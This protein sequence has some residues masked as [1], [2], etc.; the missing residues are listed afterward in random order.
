MQLYPIPLLSSCMYAI[1]T[2]SELQEIV[3]LVSLTFM[4]KVK[5][6]LL[7]SQAGVDIVFALCCKN[8]H[9]SSFCLY[10]QKWCKSIYDPPF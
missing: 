8:Q 9:C 5:H 7:G 1:K 10:F 3:L 4:L 6:L 2:I